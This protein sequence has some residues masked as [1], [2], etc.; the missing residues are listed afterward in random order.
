MIR[1]LN[2]LMILCLVVSAVVVYDVKYQ[3][4][5]KAQAVARLNG[6]IR[7]EREKIATLHAE[8][9]RLSAPERIQT[10]AERYL[11]LR[12]LDVSRIDDLSALPEK[13]AAIGDPLGDFIESLPRD[14]KPPRDAIGTM[15]D[16]LGADGD[17]PAITGSAGAGH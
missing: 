3:S 14:G 15:I 1:I 4:T 2:L 6:E 16:T 5:Y 9:S 7:S 17:A 10:L 8:W 12:P 13:P 11:G